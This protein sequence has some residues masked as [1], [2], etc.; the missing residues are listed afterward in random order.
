[1]T[2]NM[3]F[4]SKWTPLIIVITVFSLFCGVSYGANLLI[5]PHVYKYELNPYIEYLEDKD[6]TLEIED[7]IM[8]YTEPKFWTQNKEEVPNFGFSHSAYW[9]RITI[10]NPT[11]YPFVR[12]LEVAYPLLNTVALYQYEG[13]ELMASYLAGNEVSFR[14]RPIKHRNFV[15]P[16][17]VTA[18]TRSHIYLRVASH[19]GIQLP[20][21]L[22]EER[23]FWSQD[24]NKLAWQFLYYGLMAVMIAYNLFIAWG[25]RD[26]SYL[27]YVLTMASV[28]GFQMILHGSAYQFLWPEW[29]NWNAMSIAVFIP[30][31]NI[32]A[33][34]FCI[35]MLHID[36]NS[37]KAFNTLRVSIGV[38]ALLLFLNLFLPY[39]IVVP[40]SALFVVISS[41]TIIV[42]SIQRWTNNEK[43][44]QIFA[45]A[46][47]VFVGGA[48]LMALNKFAIL[49]Y[50]WYT[51]NLLQIGS[52]IETVLLSLALAAR[53]NRMREDQIDLQR[54]QLN[55]REREMQSEKQ[56]LEAKYESKAK[57]DFLAVMSHEIRTPMN[58]VLGVVDLLKET[59]LDKKQH[60]LV[61]TIHSSGRLLLNIIND[62][63][64]FSKIEAGKLE[65]EEISFQIS[66][67][68]DESISIY[69][70]NA[71]QK[72]LFLASFID[73]EIPAQIKGDPNRIKQV[74][75]NLM[76]NAIK[77]T[78]KG[79][80]FLRVSLINSTPNALRLR[81][82][83]LDSG[84]GLTDEQQ[85]KL[86][87]AFTQ[88]DKSTSR[89]FGGTGLGLAISKKLMEAM[90]GAIGVH[91]HKGEGSCFWFEIPLIKAENHPIPEPPA[92]KQEILVCSDYLPIIDFVA[93][94]LNSR[95]CSVQPVILSGFQTQIPQFNIS[96][97]KALVFV[98]KN[99][100]IE[101]KVCDFLSEN[102]QLSQGEIVVFNHSNR[103]DQLT[104]KNLS[105]TDAPFNI[106]RIICTKATTDEL[107]DN[108]E[109]ESVSNTPVS[110]L[111]ILVAEDNPVNQMVIKG[112]LKPLVGDIDVANNGKEAFYKYKN[113]SKPY[114]LIFMDCEMPEMDGYEATTC[115]RQYELDSGIKETVKIVALTA[116]AF[117]EF[118]EKAFAVGMN[119]HLTKPIN[120]AT[121]ANF[122]NNEF[123]HLDEA[124][125]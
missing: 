92:K 101:P 24:Q 110:E 27:Y 90:N 66:K 125:S 75:Y 64:D 49:P 51:E 62:I 8:D 123:N 44:E 12:L 118:R 112:M 50:N 23:V 2:R 48:V 22:W 35:Q 98:E 42:M 99:P 71:V 89:K 79:H 82:E 106:N 67:L 65:L 4:S 19:N 1:M 107:T 93:S 85:A 121:L 113:A 97:D 84:I 30:L 57:S 74:I 37:P 7:I 95:F 5:S 60:Q 111:H 53:I 96:F 40:I 80:I 116:H 100:T 94:S 69:N 28:C 43:D 91:S 47:F 76:G 9:F 114:D 72:K 41:T 87:D 122:F 54:D 18:E 13:D 39:G 16:I 78:E 34:L 59:S 26:K 55:I 77:F 58:G 45:I 20:M 120:R 115:I 109:N 32:T 117:E 104:R 81:F 31:A 63:L 86:F 36:K 15:F 68:V 103:N 119:A 70:P 61:D 11:E 29:P 25:V 73:P 6:G 10:V 56:L 83:I 46:W 21:H 88:A 52:G 124:A 33:G 105:V 38:S 17:E 14:S 102:N 108:I 3:L